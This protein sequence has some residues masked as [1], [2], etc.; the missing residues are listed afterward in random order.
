MRAR[1]IHHNAHCVW[2]P[3]NVCSIVCGLRRPQK[4]NINI[5]LL[6]GE[7]IKWIS[8]V[9]Q[10]MTIDNVLQRVKWLF[11]IL[12]ISIFSTSSSEFCFVR[13]RANKDGKHSRGGFSSYCALCNDAKRKTTDSN[14]EYLKISRF[15]N[16]F[17]WIVNKKRDKESSHT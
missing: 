17:R 11:R 3:Q 14:E 6:C 8:D 1:V 15:E 7:Y 5:Y 9:H 13:F 16:G 2:S 10:S 4:Q 12:N